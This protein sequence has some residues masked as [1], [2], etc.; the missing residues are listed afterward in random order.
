MFDKT[1]SIFSFCSKE[2]CGKLIF[3]GIWFNN[4]GPMA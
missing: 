2:V 1:L 3:S 4:K